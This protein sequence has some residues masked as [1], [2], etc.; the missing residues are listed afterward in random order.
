MELNDV[1]QQILQPFVDETIK[2]L[3]SMAGLKAH[4]G[5]G[6]PDDISKFKFKGY[7]VVA[8][9]FGNVEGKILMH[10]YVDTALAIGNKVRC[11][12]LNDDEKC[13][14]MNEEVGEALAEFSNT[15]IGLAMRQLAASNLGIKF[16]PPY[17]LSGL[18]NL[19][20]LM[21]GVKEIISIPIHVDEVGRF[22]FN[23]LLHKS[24]GNKQ[25]PLNAKILV[26]DDMKMIRSSIKSYLKQLGYENIVEAVDGQDAVEKHA[27][28]EPAFIFMD[29]V[30]PRLNGNEALKLIRDADKRVP[31]VMLTSVSDEALIKECE[32]LGVRGYVLKPL[33]RE[34]GPGTLSRMLSLE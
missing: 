31:I 16:K 19:D 9:T 33:T 11:A 2:T 29:V 30:M 13:A 6:F 23:F 15:A 1:Q 25:L 18:A 14:E 10:H 22:Y 4:A 17:Y 12:L 21:R 34:Q 7:A 3:H 8:E 28:T 20:E 5:Q 27:T 32:A 26:V 24:T